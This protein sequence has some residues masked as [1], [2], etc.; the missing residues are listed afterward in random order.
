[1]KEKPVEIHLNLADI[2]Q[3][4][5]FAKPKKIVLTHLYP[6]WDGHEGPAK[7]GRIETH[8]AFDGMTVEIGQDSKL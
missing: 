2:E 1:M 3:I 5:R 6:E 4:A 8:L 7:I